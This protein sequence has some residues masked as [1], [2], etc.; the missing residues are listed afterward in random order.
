MA[1]LSVLAFDE[2]F[3]VNCAGGVKEAGEAQEIRTIPI[4]GSASRG[5]GELG[6][7]LG[8]NGDLVKLWPSGQ[9]TGGLA[10]SCL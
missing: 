4:S 2:C 6:H 7:L 8:Q 5:P 1:G 3:D 10:H 9:E